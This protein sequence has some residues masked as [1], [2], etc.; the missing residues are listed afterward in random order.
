MGGLREF[1]LNFSSRMFL[2]FAPLVFI[3]G[4]RFLVA[5]F[6]LAGSPTPAPMVEVVRFEGAIGV[7]CFGCFGCFGFVGT[8]PSFWVFRRGL[9]L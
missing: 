6:E 8:V 3:I 2:Y 7:V 5:V 9:F 1:F 4:E